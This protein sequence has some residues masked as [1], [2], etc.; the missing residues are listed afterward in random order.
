M[1]EDLNVIL[2][3]FIQ[4]GWDLISVPS[5]G[6]RNGMVRTEDLIK[7]IGQAD[8]VCGNCGCS[9]DPLYKSALKLLAM[10]PSGFRYQKLVRDRIPEIIA[11]D[12]FVPRVRVLDDGEYLLELRRKLQEE[13]NEFSE[14]GDL[15]EI[16]DILEV[17]Y[18]ICSAKGCSEDEIHEIR[19]QKRRR[20]GGFEQKLF[21]ISKD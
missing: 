3:Q 18:A 6:W 17:L 20:R 9:L 7:A 12:G 8:E 5:A 13:V 10:E 16:A 4:S 2:D 1:K 19:A 11:Q 14:S 21:L 15:E